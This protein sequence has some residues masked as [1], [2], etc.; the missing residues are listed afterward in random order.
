MPDFLFHLPRV[1]HC[2]GDFLAEHLAKSLAQPMHRHAGG[3][4][5]Q[6]QAVPP[7]WRKE[8]PRARRS[9]TG[10]KHGKFGGLAEPLLARFPAGSAPVPA[11]SSPIDGHRAGPPPVPAAYPRS[12]GSRRTAVSSGTGTAPPPRFCARARSH[13]LARNRFNA[14]SRNVRKRPFAGRR[15]RTQR[16]SSSRAKNSWVES[17]AS[18]GE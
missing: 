15:H 6:T 8:C 9:S 12:S 17:W 3:A 18:S 7:S 13:S 5:A 10:L 2:L 14:V 16:P 4:L 11:A 1:C